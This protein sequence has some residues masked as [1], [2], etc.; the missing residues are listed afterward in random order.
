MGEAGRERFLAKFTIERTVEEVE[1]VYA[2][3]C[4]ASQ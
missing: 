4:S 1:A 3:L 2:E